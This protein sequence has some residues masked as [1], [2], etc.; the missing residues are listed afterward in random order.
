M[1]HHALHILILCTLIN[2]AILL[3]WFFVFTLAHDWLYS[4][5]SR[6]FHISVETFDTVNYAAMAVY[7]IGTMLFNLVPLI[8]L[9]FV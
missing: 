7:K 1:Y 9:H 6:W 3:I 5:H 4:L 2:Y 8:V